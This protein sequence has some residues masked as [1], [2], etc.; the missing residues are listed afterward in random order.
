M[1]SG[2]GI[3]A[4]KSTRT[5]IPKRAIKRR[6]LLAALSRRDGSGVA[7]SRRLH[8]SQRLRRWRFTDEVSTVP[9]ERRNAEIQR[10]LR[11]TKL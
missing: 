7:F 4:G 11:R 2:P 3:A 5:N 6:F 8:Q 10:R 9:V 1:A